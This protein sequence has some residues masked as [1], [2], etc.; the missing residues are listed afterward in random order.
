MVRLMCWF[1]HKHLDFREPELV[2]VADMLGVQLE[3]EPEPQPPDAEGG[4]PPVVAAGSLKKTP[5]HLSQPPSPYRFA[6][7]PDEEMAAQ[8]GSRSIMLRGILEVWGEGTTYDECVAAATAF[9]C[10]G[11]FLDKTFKINVEA[12]GKSI[13]QSQQLERINR[14]VN[15]GLRG[16]LHPPTDR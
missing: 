6:T 4:G 13:S 16:I 5:G 14:F 2:A 12:F 3:L 15:L 1:V 9:Q 11:P 7:F 8:I 10:K